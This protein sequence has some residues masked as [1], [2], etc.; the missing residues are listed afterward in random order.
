MITLNTIKKCG[1][2]TCN[3][4]HLN[5]LCEQVNQRPNQVYELIAQYG[6][7]ADSVTRETIFEYIANKYNNGDYGIAYDRWLEA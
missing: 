1:G 6:G 4:S 3:I 5:R 2:F 7:E